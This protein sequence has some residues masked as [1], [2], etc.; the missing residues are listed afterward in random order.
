[1]DYPSRSFHDT[2]TT[3]YPRLASFCE[4]GSGFSPTRTPHDYVQRR[5]NSSASSHS[6]NSL[7]CATSILSEHRYMRTPEGLQVETASKPTSDLFYRPLFLVDNQRHCPSDFQLHPVYQL[8]PLCSTSVSNTLQDVHALQAQSNLLSRDKPSGIDDS[9]AVNREQYTSFLDLK[10]ILDDS[11]LGEVDF[12]ADMEEA[13]SRPTIE[14]F[15]QDPSPRLP[16]YSSSGGTLSL[17]LAEN[18]FLEECTLNKGSNPVVK[19]DVLLVDAAHVN[20]NTFNFVQNTSTRELEGDEKTLFVRPQDVMGEKPLSMEDILIK[21]EEQ[22]NMDVDN[23]EFIYPEVPA[24]AARDIRSDSNE[25]DGPNL[26]SE[27]L[28]EVVDYFFQHIHIPKTEE[29]DH[30][31]LLSEVSQHS[32]HETLPPAYHSDTSA[33]SFI[34]R[35]DAEGMSLPTRMVFADRT[36]N[37]RTRPLHSVLEDFDNILPI[38][39]SLDRSYE[40]VSEQL[41][42]QKTKYFR[43]MNPGER[44]SD[45]LIFNFA[46]RLSANGDPILG[47]RC[48]IV[49]CGKTTKRKDHMGDHIRTHLGEKPFTCSI[50]YVYMSPHSEHYVSDQIRSGLGFIRN[51]DCQRH[52]NN[53]RPDKKFICEWLVLGFLLWSNLN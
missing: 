9:G 27:Q 22:D 48:Y 18:C 39:I 53:H 1:M 20:L 14:T 40:G 41:V 6:P 52:E 46:G 4:G 23:M 42:A 15:I 8:S 16:V 25:Q 28:C 37:S 45:D 43:M 10:E 49:G 21:S 33:E 12:I 5:S 30:E 19:S 29:H 11:L 35:H 31:V 17:R 36:N 34:V 26:T 24:T 38:D 44:L 13:L 51:N 3:C 50:W 47:Y 7:E 32:F 2:T